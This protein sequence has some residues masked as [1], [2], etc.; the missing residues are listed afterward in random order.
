MLVAWYRVCGILAVALAVADA[1][2]ALEARLID[3][4][5]GAPIAGASVSI[6]GLTGTT[7]TDSDG[8]FVWTPTP[9]P[10]FDVLVVL[11]GGRVLRPVHVTDVPG[12]GALEVGIEPM[13]EEELVVSAPVA[14]NIAAM[15]ASA[16][17]LLGRRE[18]E[19]RA[20]SNLRRH[21]SSSP[22]SCRCQRARRRSLPSVA[23]LGGARSSSSMV[24]VS[25][26]APRR[27]ERDVPRPADSRHGGSG[28]WTGFG[29]LRI[30][31]LRRRHPATT[32]RIAPARR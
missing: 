18:V 9:T 25:L 20:P 13:F 19:M 29:R 7:T 14:P 32:R 6:I 23:S 27:A 31:R 5:T 17:T 4:R 12:T 21:S 22:V 16:T 11:E 30:G 24:R 3:S 10:P 26:R 28:A 2:L 1:A 15:P 8:R